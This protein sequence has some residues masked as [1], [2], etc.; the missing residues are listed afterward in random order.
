MKKLAFF[1]TIVLLS[2]ACIGCTSSGGS[3][4]SWC[5]MGSLFP[6][7]TTAPSQQHVYM[8]AGSYDPCNPCDPPTCAP[9]EPVCNPC[10]PL[11]DPCLPRTGV[12]SRGVVTP[13]PM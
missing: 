8:T 5:R 6:V 1:C 7:A 3:T 11:C 4:S 10:E 12:Y 2:S 13:G 9:C